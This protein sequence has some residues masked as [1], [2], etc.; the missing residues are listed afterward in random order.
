LTLFFA[1]TFAAL[2]QTFPQIIAPH[3]SAVSVALMPF[4][5]SKEQLSFPTRHSVAKD[6]RE[7]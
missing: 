1:E 4:A 2:R 7:R 6:K 5:L 3:Y